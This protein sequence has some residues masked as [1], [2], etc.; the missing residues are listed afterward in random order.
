MS[1]TSAIANCSH[2][3]T[4]RG[5]EDNTRPRG[6]WVQPEE[7][8]GQAQMQRSRLI[9]GAYLYSP[10]LQLFAPARGRFDDVRESTPSEKVGLCDDSLIRLPPTG[11]PN[12]HLIV[13]F[14][15]DRGDC[16]VLASVKPSPHAPYLP[17]SLTTHSKGREE[18]LS[19]HPS[20]DHTIDHRDQA[21]HTRYYFPRLAAS[22]ISIPAN[23][24]TSHD[25]CRSVRRLSGR[26]KVTNTPSRS[27]PHSSVSG[28]REDH[29]DVRGGV[30]WPYPF[31]VH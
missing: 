27:T 12:L 1:T 22:T 21:N 2:R 31:L 20:S 24:S 10:L 8:N 4:T 11:S 19:I 13:D 28:P 30:V 7:I 17:F 3:F 6:L 25:R 9:A 26:P 29:A 16:R 23:L 14:S 5:S 18:S 15:L